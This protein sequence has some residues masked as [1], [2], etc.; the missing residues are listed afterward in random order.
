MPLLTNYNLRP[1]NRKISSLESENELLRQ[2]CAQL[3][4]GSSAVEPSNTLQGHLH[5]STAL[6]S[7]PARRPDSTT[8]AKNTVQTEASDGAHVNTGPL[9][10]GP[11]STYY[12]TPESPQQESPQAIPSSDEASQS[13]LFAQTA[14]QSKAYRK[15]NPSSLANTWDRATGATQYRS[16]PS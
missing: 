9:Y 12:D 3:A 10:H 11:T 13:F 14:R 1:T 2:R 4:S 5:A 8:P 16:Q 6:S 15:L 7:S